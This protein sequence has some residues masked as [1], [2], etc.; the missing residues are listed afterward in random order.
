MYK[1]VLLVV[2][3]LTAPYP[4]LYAAVSE[5]TMQDVKVRVTQAA[6]IRI[7]PISLVNS[8]EI[9]AHADSD[10]QRITIYTGM[11]NFVNSADELAVVLAHEVCH[12]LENDVGAVMEQ[13][14]QA[15]ICGRDLMQ[16]AGYNPQAGVRYHSRYIQQYGDIGPPT[17]P[18][19]STRK[20]FYRTG[21]KGLYYDK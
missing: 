10:N 17:H 3:A 1:R 6:G 7:G 4:T 15:D 19:A 2:L 5:G 9:N 21:D 16:K 8:S 13:E 11:L 20:E 12:L 18:Y 14:K